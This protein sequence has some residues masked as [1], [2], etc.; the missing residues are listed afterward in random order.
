M[1]HPPAILVSSCLLGVACRYDGGRKPNA[2]VMELGKTYHLIPVCPEIL[3]GLPTPRSPSERNGQGVKNQL[4]QDVTAAY[5]K[6]AQE[7][8]ALARL[9]GC[10]LAILKE[11]SPACGSGQIY[12]GSFT[13]TLCEGDGVATQRLKEH[14][15]LVFG[16]SQVA[17]LLKYLDTEKP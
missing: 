6:G 1:T 10:T 12:D 17:Q 13:G 2:Q 16:E 11:R 8:M 4:G 9:F 7:T 14:G 3:G 5:E 15:I